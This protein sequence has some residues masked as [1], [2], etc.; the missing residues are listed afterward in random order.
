MGR[1]GRYAPTTPADADPAVLGADGNEVGMS[2]AAAARRRARAAGRRRCFCF[3][4]F[5][6]RHLCAS[7][8]LRAKARPRLRASMQAG[9][10]MSDF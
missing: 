6:L 1:A 4:P 5:A 8:G 2:S 3:F 9:S 7:V 10:R